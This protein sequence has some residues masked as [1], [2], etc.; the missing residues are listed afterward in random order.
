MEGRLQAGEGR[1][2]WGDRR[3][4]RGDRRVK[5][6]QSSSLQIKRSLP[7]ATTSANLGQPDRPEHCNPKRDR[8]LEKSDR[9]AIHQPLCQ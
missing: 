6:R 8:L 7:K 9:P 3:L 4:G 5:Q 2:R 1:L